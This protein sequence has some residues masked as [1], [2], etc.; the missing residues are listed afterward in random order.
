[1]KVLH[2]YVSSEIVM[3]VSFALAAFLALFAF[4]DLIGELPDVGRGGYR[5]QHAFLY[6]AM[7][8]PGY[9][10]D[11]MPIAALIG[12]IYTLAQLGARSEFTIMRASGLST[13]MAGWMLAKVG[14][15]FVINT[16]LFGEVIAPATSEMGERLKL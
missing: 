15:V 10:Y 8:L 11:L 2:R 6:V 4:F 1:M 9:V 12:T 3:A 13:A 7:G 5:L 14:I 16:F